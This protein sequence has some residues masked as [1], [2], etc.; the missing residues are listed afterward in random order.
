M[1]AKLA[2]RIE[3]MADTAVPLVRKELVDAEKPLVKQALEQ[4]TA[5]KV[6]DDASR[7]KGTS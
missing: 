1:Q 6:T 2:G 4:G 3:K 5:R 7:P